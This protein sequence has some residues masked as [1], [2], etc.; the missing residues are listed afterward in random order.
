MAET[1]ILSKIGVGSGLD[2]TA[3]IKAL[4]D[5][6]SAA[7]TSQLEKDEE[8]TNAKISALGT[9]KSNLK[10]FNNIIKSIQT[11]ES[12]GFVGNSSN[13]ATATLTASGDAAGADIDS[14]LTVT[15]LASSHTL[16]GPAY[17]ATTS[18]VGAGS[19]SIAFGTW[20]AD[21]TS[22][23]GQSH[24]ANSQST[25]SVNTTSSTT[26]KDLRD[27]IN[28]A[29]TDSDSDGE[30]DV[31]ASII[32]DGTNYM[33]MLKSESGASNEMKV[34]ASSDLA[35]TIS[36]VSYNYNATTSNMTQRVSGIN[37]AFTVDGISMT[38]S[39]NEIKD[40]FDGFTLDLLATNSSAIRVSSQVDLTKIKALMNDYVLTYNE[41]MSLID[42]LTTSGDTALGGSNEAGALNGNS[43]LM[44]IKSQ[45]RGLS[46]K[47]IGGYEGGPY[48]LS[49]MGIKTERDGSL[50]LN[51]S[52]LEESFDFNPEMVHAFFSDQLKT[53]TNGISVSSFELLNT[54]PGT[55]A[56]ATNGSTH[57]I[58]GVNATKNGTKY[59]VSSGDPNGLVLNVANGITSG[60]VYYGKSFLSLA[61]ETVEVF[62]KFD[63]VIDTQVES[64]RSR[65]KDLAEKRLRLEDRIE[66]L[67]QRYQKQYANME[68]AVAGLNETGNM[69]TALLGNND[70]D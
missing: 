43:L 12:S 44:S 2:T 69:L 61:H 33:L 42:S 4:V 8:K 62:T 19:I 57:T 40:L 47:S 54:K 18:T 48:F 68:S 21:P 37:S 70:D 32:Y 60:N 9:L 11:S 6:D 24:T 35:N 46:T 25:I 20:S 66:K 36:G 14:S 50:T 28:N 13:T 67:T 65:I 52:D 22:G 64:G 39:S 5:A 27:L 31:L 41:V 17:S 51:Q 59:S 34:T 55:Y 7:E 29:A 15:T 3:L 38:R 56:F 53:D 30:R 1:E 63:S 10:Q 49:Q 45:L 16:T 26:L 23:G 58:G